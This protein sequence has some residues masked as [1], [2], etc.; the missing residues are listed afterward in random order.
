MLFR[1]EKH[2][3]SEPGSLNRGLFRT[4]RS[5]AQ[6]RQQLKDA[7][8]GKETEPKDARDRSAKMA[9]SKSILSDGY[10]ELGTFLSSVF[11]S[12]STVNSRFER[13]RIRCARKGS[14]SRRPRG[15]A[16]ADLPSEL[17]P[18]SAFR[19]TAWHSC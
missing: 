14:S 17:P 12:T 18:S 8:Q 19:K 1:I 6:G 11:W 13:K 4:Q 9:Q 3:C 7:G 16:R 15:Q 5:V 2:R 10:L